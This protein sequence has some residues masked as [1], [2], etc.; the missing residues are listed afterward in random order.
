MGYISKVLVHKLSHLVL[1]SMWSMYWYL[2]EKKSLKRLTDL[3]AQG[4]TVN[5][6]WSWDINW[7]LLILS[8]TLQLFIKALVCTILTER[9]L[10]RNPFEKKAIPKVYFV[11]HYLNYFGFTSGETVIFQMHKSLHSEDGVTEAKNWPVK[12]CKISPSPISH[13][14][15]TGSKNHRRRES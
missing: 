11:S 7:D 14:Q 12:E 15:N 4:H 1:T 13:C 8:T 5:K 3:S 9:H 10:L 6:W 2:G